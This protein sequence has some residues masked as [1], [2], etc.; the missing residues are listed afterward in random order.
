MVSTIFCFV[1]IVDYTASFIVLRLGG[2]IVPYIIY[3]HTITFS[4]INTV[5]K[6]AED[7]ARP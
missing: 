4:I 2:S 7:K 1:T 3:M 6:K 5:A